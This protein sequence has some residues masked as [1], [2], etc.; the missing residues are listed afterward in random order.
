M[1]GS[2]ISMPKN[3]KKTFQTPLNLIFDYPVHWSKYKVLRDF[4]QNFYDAVGWIDW[5][6]RFSY[7]VEN[8]KLLL[9]V[10]NV[11]FSYEWLLHI[12]ASTKREDTKNYAGY[13]GEGFK[14]ASLCA[15]RDHGWN[16]FLES[17]DW[18][19]DV[20]T[21]DINVDN[22][23]LKTLAYNIQ[24]FENELVDTSLVIEN[25]HDF[26]IL[27]TVLLSFYHP[28][29]ELFGEKIF[30]SEKI[31]VYYRSQIE[32]PRGYPQTYR[33]Y[34]QGIVFSAYQALGS[35]HGNLIFCLHDHK[36]HDRERTTFYSMDVIDLIQSTVWHLPP[37]ASATVLKTLRKRWYE[38]P[39]KRY[40]FDSWYK[41]IRVLCQNTA[42]C[43]EQRKQWIHD[44]PELLVAENVRKTNI[45]AYNKRRQAL[46]WLRDNGGISRLVQ[47]GF[48]AFGYRTLEDACA[49]DDGYS[50]TRPPTF[51]EL[52]YIQILEDMV[53][54]I[55]PDWPDHATLPPTEI[56][57]YG[58]GSWQGMA[59][60][61]AIK[62]KQM[63]Y[64]E[65]SLRYRLSRVALQEHLLHPGLLANALST[66]LHELAHVFGTDGSA[67]FS[68]ALSMLM[69]AVIENARL[70]AAYEQQWDALLEGAGEQPSQERQVRADP[71]GL[72]KESRPGQ[73]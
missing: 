20:V 35:F 14:I 22:K 46:V 27:K 64:R 69:E 23:I 21:S 1:I 19:L 37:E 57:K 6:S 58:K 61:H 12:G 36:K 67:G 38:R 5:R 73:A 2:E 51:P 63:K 55:L 29:N 47:D 54:A 10:K 60:C 13:F 56:L 31:A 39:K 66:Y 33:S 11:G 8:D 30:D 9:H 68:R 15:V 43:S 44:Y 72:R 24:L 3:I 65:L 18:S 45:S 42:R 49:D 62:D 26:D 28:E 16:V 71:K 4:V 59:T 50:V 40:D 70:I 17:R 7:Q 34:G 48:L 25:F 41:I 52:R 32:M 53:R